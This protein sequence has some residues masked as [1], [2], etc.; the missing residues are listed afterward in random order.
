MHENVDHAIPITFEGQLPQP[1]GGTREKPQERAQVDVDSYP[2]FTVEGLT[3]HAMP[4]PNT[5][6][7]SQPCSIQPLHFFVEGPPLVAEGKGKLN[8]I[9]KRLRAV[10]G[11][12]DYPFADMTD[13]C[14]VPDVVIPPKFKVPDFDRY[15]GTTCPKHHLK[16]YC[17]KMG[18]YSRDENL[19]LHFFQDSLA[20]AVNTWYASLE[21]SQI[22]SWKDQMVAFV[23]QYQYNADMAPDRIQ[24]Q[25]VC[26][27]EHKSFKEYAQR[28]RD[29]AAQV[30]PPMMEREMITMIVDTLPVFYFEKLVGYMPSSFTDLVFVGKRIEVGL[31]RGNF[32]YV[33]PTSTSNR[34]SGP[35]GA[36]RKEG[37]AHAVTSAPV[38]PKPQSTPLNTH[39]YAQHHPSFSARAGN[40]SNSVPVQ[41][42]TSA[43][44]QRALA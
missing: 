22:H 39:Q 25:N 11:S 1:I 3:F 36:K 42:R 17:R 20:G 6:E 26:K 34:R 14:L 23:R 33:T 27:K 28:L 30:A 35:T 5:A 12:E 21:P 8:L 9:Q 24:L 37:D 40:S 44:P 15:K 38:W 32:D 18:A 2:P 19:L 29:L 41:Q 7:A 10:E 13:L 43:L 31:K 16:M 4:Q